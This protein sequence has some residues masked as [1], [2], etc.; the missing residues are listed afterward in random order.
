MDI[1]P[2]NHTNSHLMMTRRFAP[3]FWTQFLSAFN[4]NFLKNTLVFL[5]LFTLAADKAASLVTLAGA[6]FMAPFLFL[7]ALGG[8]IADRFDKA[9]IARRL[10]F[11]EI[12]AAGV[13]VVGI[14][15]SSIP[16]L[17]VALLMFG[18]ISALFGPIK[19][20]ILPDHLERKE[21]PGANAWIESA[22]FAAI[23][24]GTI[25]G[26]VVSA[27]G[28]GVSV[29]GPIMMILAVSCW[30]VSRYIPSTGS[31]AP[32]LV[33][34]KNV[35][36]STWRQVNGLRGDKR[37]WRAGLMTSWFWLIGAIVLSILPT[38]IKDS[39][40]GN[41][42]AV[43]AYLAV[44]AVSIAIGSAIAAWMSQ[45]R[46]VLLPAPVGT[47]L[48]ALF[49]LDLAWTIW[50]MQP[51]PRTETLAL[52]FA[53]PNT[54]HVAID[55]AGMAIASAFLVVP[56]FAAVQAWSPEER[57][58]RV[59]AA[60]SIVNAGFMTVGGILVAAIQAAGASTG[61]I[62][63]G[64][65]AA[66]AIA[67]WL[68]LK[69]LPTNAFRDF[70]SI[71]FRAF[72]RLE[73][74]GMENL[75]AAGPAPIL[76]LNHVSFLDGPLALT[77]T[78]EEPV[79][80][81]DHTIAQAWWM[82]PFM[83][84]A[85]ALPLNPSKPMSTRTLIKIVQG[86]DPLVIF[87]EGRI[88][89]TGGLMKVYDGAAMV[90]DKTGSMVVPVRIDGLEK[91]YFSRLTSQHVRRRLFPKVKVTILE[92]VKLEVPQEL[93]G[94]KRRAAAGVALYQV[95]SDLVFR[96]QDIDKT[97]LEKIIQT[98]NERGMRELAVQDPVTGSLSYGKLLTAAAVLGEKFQNL[99]A[100]QQTLGIML[101]N[102]NGSCA[103]LL[104]VMSAGKVPAMMN[105]T[106]GAAN[107]LSACKAAEVRTVLTSRAF[108]EQAKLGGVIE[109]IGRSV[110]IVWLD[111]LRKTVGLKDKLLGLLRKSTPRAPRKPDDAAVI[112]FTSG[113]EGTPKG[114]VLTHR[115]ILAN[116]AQAASRIDFHS[117]DKVFNVLPIF[118]SFGMTA[119][120]VL[121]LISGVPVYFYPSP[122]HYRIVPELIYASNATII[123]GT[124]TFLAGYARTAHPYDFR[125]I[126]YCFAGAEPVKAATRMTYMEKFG[127]RILEGYGVTETAP[128]ISI[129]TPMYNRSGTVGKIMPG[130]EYRLDPVPGVDDGGRLFVRGPNVMA[131]YLRAE[132]PGVLEPLEDGWHDTGDV[133]AVDDVGFI[134]IRG[135]AK[136]FAKIG[137]EMISLAA[138]EALAGE[139]WKG[140]L[141]AVATVPDA[142]KG[143]KLILITE[144][145][146]ATR[147]EFLT[148]A[149]ANGA[150]DLMVPAEV[151]AVAKVPVLGSGKLD[152]A[153]VTKLV[154]GE[155]EMKIKVA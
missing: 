122:L 78:D 17:M 87:P 137:G 13:A 30:I 67:A 79:F 116:A 50:S 43:T 18:I 83:K 82:K 34:D 143:E 2:N 38:L 86:G 152:F 90:A 41:E 60:V 14:A 95:M 147:A 134:T 111:D 115:N 31:A 91:S 141:S 33:I 77:L 8:E 81:I 70:V 48:L 153:A 63:F 22:T 37:I 16:V 3:L 119:G 32:D 27:D 23:L 113:S 127:V 65:A 108:I 93:K 6:V 131:G 146:N 45:G 72:H 12:V 39:L 132:K 52:F 24:G 84:L 66:N 47:A 80:A 103:T 10:K 96:T 138:I 49:G 46:I 102:A 26:G 149:K 25:A 142:R 62:L 5:I 97:V 44:F 136:R 133:V 125:S 58:A 123:F 28:I 55:L 1:A 9:L 19:Y 29:F 140:S 117:G 154:R 135:R 85:R 130:M 54:I 148:F 112:L 69:Y 114:V 61:A 110:D 59:V 118:H 94:R 7:S 100:G 92:P 101:P 53:G 51:S 129:N 35:F 150:M 144:A 21:L 124:D 68:M 74:E 139:L 20:G 104:G 145:A 128:V 89:V 107:I 64:L 120:T 36:R 57:R 106:A 155:E 88:T 73:V 15:L 71:L 42:I 109:E 56:T 76:A 151:R 40:G 126:R 75:K 105:F 99:Y 4:D 121:P 98:A 11:T